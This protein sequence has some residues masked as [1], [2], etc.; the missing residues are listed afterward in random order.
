MHQYERLE[1]WTRGIQLAA[2]LQRMA[3][4]TRGAW[5]DRALWEQ[6]ARAAVSIPANVAEGAQRGS[7][8]EFSRFLAISMGSAAELH[9]LLFLAAESDA[10]DRERAHQLAGE[11]VELRRMAAALRAR[12]QGR[13]REPN[14]K[15]PHVDSRE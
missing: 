6:I 5:P 11:A 3:R 12:V 7:S 9:S 13:R 15:A 2:Q 4:V 1:I 14:S 8:A 10:L